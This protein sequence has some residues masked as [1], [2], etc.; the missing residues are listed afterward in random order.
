V[1]EAVIVATA[2]TPIGR[3]FKGSLKDLRPDDLSAQVVQG[4]LAKLPGLDRESIDDLYWGCAD[5]SDK[6]GSNMARVIA[7]LAGMDHLPA[8][9]VNRFCASSTQTMRMAFHAIKA[10]EGDTFLVGGVEC[11]SQYTR[12]A[13]AGGSDLD[14]QNPLFSDAAARAAEMARTNVTWTDPREQGLLPDV[15]LA[16]GQ[17]AENVATYRGVS[18]QRQDEWGVLSQNRAEK[19]IADG[20]FAREILPVTTPDGTVVSTDDGPRAGVTLEAVQTLNPVFRENGTVTAGNCCPLNDGASGVVVMSD[21]RAR[22]LGLTPLARIVSTGV[23]ALSPEIMGLGPVEASKQA[24]ARAGM[25]IDDMDLYEINEAFAAQVLPSADD[26]GMDLEKVNVH[27]GAI[28]LGHPFGSTGTR[29]MTTLLNGLQSR[30]GQFGLETMCVGGGQ[31]MAIV[32]ERL[33]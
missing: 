33:S 17:T 8:A 21:S 24:L 20:F 5:P 9:T 27:G 28:A 14:N 22:E 19:A 15:Y 26:L 13:G 18:R 16:M 11:V 29:I 6:H 7:V 25:T 12:F 3:A 1:T 10:G 4:L 23:S 2:R 31:G 30:D 32:V